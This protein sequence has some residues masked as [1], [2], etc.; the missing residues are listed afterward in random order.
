MI[1]AMPLDASDNTNNKCIGV[2]A[3]L[4]STIPKTAVRMESVHVYGRMDRPDAVRPEAKVIH[5]CLSNAVGNDNQTICVSAKKHGLP[6]AKRPVAFIAC[7]DDQRF[8]LNRTYGHGGYDMGIT[9]MGVDNTEV[10]IA[11]P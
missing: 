2:N 10:I 5:H 6:E 11:E 3:E 4:F 7:A 1:A 9:E 8:F